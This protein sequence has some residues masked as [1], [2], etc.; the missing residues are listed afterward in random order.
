MTAQEIIE[1]VSA[2]QSG[3]TIE[4]R[5]RNNKNSPW[6]TDLEPAWNFAHFDYRA[7]PKPREWWLLPVE[8]KEPLAFSDKADAIGYGAERGHDVT[9]MLVRVIEA[10]EDQP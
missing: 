3:E 4:R 2:F 10:P 9:S 7:K 8:P 5:H 1:T 6:E